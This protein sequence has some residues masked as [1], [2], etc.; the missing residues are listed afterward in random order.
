MLDGL[1]AFIDLDRLQR[2]RTTD[3]M[4]RIGE[5]VA[6]R[7]DFAALIEH[8]LVEL[9]FDGDGA[10]REIG[11]GDRLRHRD[12][13]GFHAH[14]RGA[15]PFA[16]TPEAADH[17][18]GDDAHVIFGEHRIDLGEIAFGRDDDAA[19]PHDRFGDEGRDRIG[20]LLLDQVV[21]ILRHAIGEL[22]FALA[23]FGEAVMMRARRVQDVGDRQIETTMHPRQASKRGAGDGDA[24]IGALARDDL[25]LF[26][27]SFG[28]VHIPGELDLHVIGFRA[29]PAEQHF[30]GGAGCYLLQLLRQ[31]DV[32]QDRR[33]RQ[34]RAVRPAREDRALVEA[35]AVDVHLLVPPLEAL[36]DH[37]LG[38][39]V[40]AVQR[41]AA[42]RVV[43]VVLVVA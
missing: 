9:F 34:R 41:V 33:V 3:R 24:V 14:G 29:R 5:A 1:V 4:R 28:I 12:R 30:R 43:H 7:A 31:L 8:R 16:G 21:E 11:R 10:H 26:R 37:L 27:P 18:I 23:R 36:D 40:V 15:E 19:R 35:E 38:D 39:R 22:V 2:H 42:A 20:S 6:E 25:L 13:G 17:F 32:P